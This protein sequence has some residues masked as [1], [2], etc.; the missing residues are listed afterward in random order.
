M[1]NLITKFPPL[2]F[3]SIAYNYIFEL[4]YKDLFIN[5]NDYYYFMILFPNNQSDTS[6]NENWYMGLPFLFQNKKFCICFK[7]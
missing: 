5:I 6:S 3:S 1:D 2:Y 7:K 4:T